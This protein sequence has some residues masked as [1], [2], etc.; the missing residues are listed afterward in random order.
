MIQQSASEQREQRKD[1]H[2]MQQ[3]IQTLAVTMASTLSHIQQHSVSHPPV[4]AGVPDALN[5]ARLGCLPPTPPSAGPAI[6]IRSAAQP[7]PA[8]PTTQSAPPLA[9][10]LPSC[11]SH[12]MIIGPRRIYYDPNQLLAP[13]CRNYSA[14]PELLANDWEHL[15]VVLCP[16][17]CEDIGVKY[18]KQLYKGTIHWTR[19]R[20]YYSIWAVHMP[21][22]ALRLY[23]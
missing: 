17:R 16:G 19:L 3:S 4:P 12:S 6:Y 8:M 13:P 9:G 18:W 14:N 23:L 11:Q 10:P 20:R 5:D 22:L 2:A 21:S 1:L 15:Q 7:P